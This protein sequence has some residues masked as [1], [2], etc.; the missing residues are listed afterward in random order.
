MGACI[1]PLSMAEIAV[2]APRA[3]IAPP[4]HPRHLLVLRLSKDMRS[5][6]INGLQKR[7]VKSRA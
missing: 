2:G 1:L 5:N 3:Y 7:E 6:D 4:T